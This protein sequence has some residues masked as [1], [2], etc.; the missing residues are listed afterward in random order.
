MPRKKLT[1]KTLSENQEGLLALFKALNVNANISLYAQLV[2][3][4]IVKLDGRDISKEDG[5]V[6]VSND[7]MRKGCEI[8]SDTRA[9]AV[10]EL[11][12]AG[13]I[14]VERGKKRS[15]GEKGVEN[16]YF[17]SDEIKQKIHPE[18]NSSVYSTETDKTNSS[19]Y[20]TE[21]NQQMEEVL[22]R[23]EALE[24]RIN[25][26]T[27]EKRVLSEKV[28]TIAEKRKSSMDM[29]VDMEINSCNISCNHLSNINNSSSNNTIPERSCTGDVDEEKCTG[30]KYHQPEP[31]PY[32][33]NPKYFDTT[34]EPVKRKKST[35]KDSSSLQII[36][37]ENHPDTNASSN[38]EPDQ[39]DRL[40]IS[41][42]DDRNTT[43]NPLE[44]SKAYQNVLSYIRQSLDS[45][46]DELLDA[47]ADNL[48][49]KL[50]REINPDIAGEIHR[51]VCG[52]ASEIIEPYRDYHDSY[53]SVKGFV[54]MSTLINDAKAKMSR[55]LIEMEKN[56]RPQM[57]PKLTNDPI[58]VREA[59]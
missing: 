33:F 29:E 4:Y 10:V 42:L 23:I 6:H 19:V 28:E 32:V 35:C 51:L 53:N 58:C 40:D 26:L 54:P 57:Y 12:N 2:C 50:K 27:E 13:L 55:R 56:P 14:T 1:E 37:E 31:K 44:K 7:E 24:L 52:K 39:A 43:P 45:A 25:E 59:V 11:V 46:V 21:K 49:R 5:Y 41:Q 8:G 22:K 48:F 16:R 38:T 34:P 47:E 30:S 15:K 18:T 20:S 9:N 3:G 36:E 17:L